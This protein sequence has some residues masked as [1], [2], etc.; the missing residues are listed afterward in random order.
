MI[1]YLNCR[2]VL[3]FYHLMSQIS[4]TYAQLAKT[5]LYDLLD[6]DQF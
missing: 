4:N 5:K 3:L 1:L 2:P 6:M